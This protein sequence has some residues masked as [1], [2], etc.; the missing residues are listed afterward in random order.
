M[1]GGTRWGRIQ[2]AG[3][4]MAAGMKVPAWSPYPQGLDV[5][6]GAQDTGEGPSSGPSWLGPLLGFSMKVPRSQETPVNQAVLG[7]LVPGNALSPQ[8]P[9]IP[10]YLV[11]WGWE[12]GGGRLLPEAK[13]ARE[14]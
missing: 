11:E 2:A 10:R 1:R 7:P 12:E 14:R 9:L 4:G 8:A 13:M 3:H 6:Y 5:W